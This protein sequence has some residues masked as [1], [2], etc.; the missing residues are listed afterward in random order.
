MGWS[1]VD[2]IGSKEDFE[3]LEEFT[4]DKCAKK[5]VSSIRVIGR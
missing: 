2:F 1:W 5:D 3:I 4:H